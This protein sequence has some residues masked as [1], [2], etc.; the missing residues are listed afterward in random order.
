MLDHQPGQLTFDLDGGEEVERNFSDLVNALCHPVEA[1]RLGSIGA[2]QVREHKWFSAIEWDALQR[3]NAMSPL[4]GL[5]SKR[6]QEIIG[7]DGAPQLIRTLGAITDPPD[8]SLFEAFGTVHPKAGQGFSS[9]MLK[10]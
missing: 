10:R 6:M 4:V 3:G 2:A 7:A 9:Q 8:Q 1:H 5:C